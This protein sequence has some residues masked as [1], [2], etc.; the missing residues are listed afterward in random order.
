MAMDG[1]HREPGSDLRYMIGIGGCGMSGLAGLYHARG[2]PVAGTDAYDS[3]TTEALHHLGIPVSTG[4]PPVAFPHGVRTVVASAA[5]KPDHPLLVDARNKGMPVLSYAQALGEAM[6][7][8]TGVAVAGTHGKS[9]TTA[10]LGVC[11]AEAGLDPTVIVGATSSHF[12]DASGRPTGFRLGSRQTPAGRFEGRPG[13]LVAEACEYN[14]SFH[15]LAPRVASIGSVEA[16]HLDIYGTVDAVIEAFRGF[17]QLL[18]P[19][20]PDPA[21][22]GTLIIGHDAAH[23]REVT[24]GAACDVRTIGFNPAADWHVR[25]DQ[26]TR[27]VGL[28]FRGELVASFTSPMPGEHNALNACTAFALAE[29]LG[30][31]REAVVRG[32]AA[33]RGV[34]R[35]LERLGDRELPGGGSARVYD[36]YGHHPTEVDMTLRAI[37]AHERI[38]APRRL[39]CVFQPHQHSRTRFFLDEFANAFE[40]ADLVIV[41]HIYFVRDSEAERQMVS[42]ADLVDRLG[43]RGVNALHIDSFEA[44]AEQLEAIVRDGDVLVVMGAG[45]VWQVARAFMDRTLLAGQRA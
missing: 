19:A 38:D 32:L 17:A 16:D 35:R 21:R 36:D 10:M 14:R 31:D 29:S 33:F 43:R 2:L 28:S 8:M 7:G 22:A 45:P 34:H 24:R 11:L 42:A 18:P 20:D 4:R 5:V 3:D 44:I 13:L 40:Q 6:R 27:R 9:T 30:A 12:P 39:I 23:R 37:R 26:A 25:F 15:S 1:T 41:P